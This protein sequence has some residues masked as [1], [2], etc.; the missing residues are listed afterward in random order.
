MFALK[1]QKTQGSCSRELRGERQLGA[2]H[3][4]SQHFQY[5]LLAARRACAIGS[6]DNVSVRDSPLPL[7]VSPTPYLLT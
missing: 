1:N 4:Q 7:L 2:S 5:S 3:S 6:N